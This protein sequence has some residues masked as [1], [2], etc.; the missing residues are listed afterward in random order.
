MPTNNT[1]AILQHTSMTKE[2]A[3]VSTHLIIGCKL[4]K[5]EE[6]H[7]M[8]ATLYRSMIGGILCVTTLDM[9]HAIRIVALFQSSPKESHML[10]IKR[11]FIYLK[12]TLN[13]GLW[14]PKN[15]NMTLK[16]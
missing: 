16:T 13:F 9:M 8:D 4:S 10:A 11:I 6:S 12:G 2:C 15:T 7:M 14:Y 3:I 1:S 5:D